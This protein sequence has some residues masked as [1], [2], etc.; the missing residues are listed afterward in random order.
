MT[1]AYM[2]GCFIG[3]GIILIIHRLYLMYIVHLDKKALIAALERIGIEHKTYTATCSVCNKAFQTSIPPL[4]N[5]IG[6]PPTDFCS[7]ACF[8]KDRYNAHY[9]DT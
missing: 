7:Q 6:T 4:K 8:G 1:W 5:P 9:Y 3:L 2:L